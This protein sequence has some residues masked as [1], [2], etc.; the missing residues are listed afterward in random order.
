MQADQPSFWRKILSALRL[1]PGEPG[2]VHERP[3]PA[4][5]TSRLPDPSTFEPGDFIWP[6]RKGAIVVRGA[7]PQPA[8]DEQRAWEA[9]R[10][11]LFTQPTRSLRSTAIAERLKSMRYE[12]F[13]R[14]YFEGLSDSAA[15]RGVDIA[16]I[17]L[18]V[19]HVGIVEIDAQSRPFVIEA[20]PTSRLAVLGGGTVARSSYQDWLARHPDTQLWHGRVKEL[21]RRMRARI[22]EE[23]AKQLGKP[24]DFFNFDLNDDSGFYCS[25]LAWMS[26]W[27][28][29]SIAAD[30]DPDPQR[31]DRFP[32]WFSPRELLNSRRILLLRRPDE[33]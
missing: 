25:K 24:Y 20:I 3:L 30:D 23:A 29:A 16:G 11:R 18:S 28:A 4:S 26:I 2:T 32:P 27:R 15:T 10:D 8:S 5:D 13:E 9:Q 31:G 21:E 17:K 6:K 7:T 19:G 1:G 14:I 22:F 33:F 12:E